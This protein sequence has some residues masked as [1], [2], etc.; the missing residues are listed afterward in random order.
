MKR[1]EIMTDSSAT[2]RRFEN[3]G[4]LCLL[5]IVAVCILISGHAVAM[6]PP[7]DECEED[8]IRITVLNDPLYLTTLVPCTAEVGN[9]ALN[10]ATGA[11]T[12]SP[13]LTIV[14][15]PA[16]AVVRVDSRQRGGDAADKR[17]L[18]EINPDTELSSGGNV[19][20]VED[21]RLSPCNCD[22]TTQAGD[23]RIDYFVGGTLEVEDNQAAGTYT[24]TIPIIAECD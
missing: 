23:A 2:S 21:I 16:R 12:S 22:A 7:P 24:G 1:I 10:Q 20:N 3:I 11:L 4:A 19:M 13:C 5:L 8:R 17:V 6:G 18:V 14:D 15:M 9:V